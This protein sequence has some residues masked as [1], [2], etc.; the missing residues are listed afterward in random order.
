M[1]N[2]YIGE[3]LP[4]DICLFVPEGVGTTVG[5]GLV[6]GR[7]LFQIPGTLISCAANCPPPDVQTERRDWHPEALEA[8]PVS[9]GTMGLRALAEDKILLLLTQRTSI[10]LPIF[11]WLSNLLK[12]GSWI[13]PGYS[14]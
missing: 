4:R 8:N 11:C 7:F 3:T 9:L 6:G 14:S 12:F 10:Y 5:A 1:C 2:L 13:F